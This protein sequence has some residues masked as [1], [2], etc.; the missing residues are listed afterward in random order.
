MVKLMFKLSQA[1]QQQSQWLFLLYQNK[2]QMYNLV[3]QLIIIL[4]QK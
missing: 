1:N 3:I 2:L 4:P